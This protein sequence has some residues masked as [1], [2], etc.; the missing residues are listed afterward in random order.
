MR[1]KYL[2]QKVFILASWFVCVYVISHI[3]AVFLINL[4]INVAFACTPLILAKRVHLCSSVCQAT[5][6]QGV[7]FI[8]RLMSW[9]IAIGYIWPTKFA[10]FSQQICIAEFTRP[11]LM[12]QQSGRSIINH[13][14][15]QRNSQRPFSTC[16]SFGRALFLSLSTCG[17]HAVLRKSRLPNMSTLQ[18]P[19]ICMVNWTVYCCGCSPRVMSKHSW[20]FQVLTL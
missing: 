18:T 15:A 14:C 10:G 19:N 13:C 16:L 6:P 3:L 1:H 17:F 5:R 20:A 8:K 4:W 9:D 7:F 12:Q 11:V 2:I